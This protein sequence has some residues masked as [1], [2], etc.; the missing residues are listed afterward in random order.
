[1]AKTELGKAYVQIIPSAEGITGSISNVLDGEATSA[2]RSAGSRIS[3][4]IGTA[5]KAGGAVMAAGIAT[6]GAALV[7]LGSEAVNAYANFEQLSGGVET[8]FGESADLVMANADNAFKTAGLSANQYMETVTSFS[9]SLLQSTAGNTEE[10]A[11]IADMAL[12]DMADNANKMG[13][14]MQSIMNAYQGFAKGQYQLLDNL[15]LGYGGTQSEMER[16][17]ADATALSG[18]EYDIS[19][20]ADVYEAIHVIQSDIGITGTTALEASSTIQG[21]IG[22]MSAAWTN[23]IT[24]MADPS[25]DFDV[26]IGNL[27]DSVVGVADNIAPRI[28]AMVPRLVSGLVD[29]INALMPQIPP[30]VQ[31]LLPVFI[32]GIQGLLTS[33]IQMMP[34]LMNII[35]AAMPQIL[36]LISQILPMLVEVAAQIIITLANGLTAMMPDLIPV[37]IDMIVL[38]MN[39][40]IQNLPLIIEA[41]IQ[42][43]IALV[44]GILNNLPTVINGII[45]VIS[46]LISTIV[47]H[48][49]EIILMGVELLKSLLLGIANNLP[50]VVQSGIDLIVS[51][52]SGLIEAIPQIIAAMPEIIAAI[53]DTLTSVDWLGLGVNIVEGL[54]K[55]IASMASALI[56]VMVNLAKSA[57]QS[58]KEFFGIASPSKLM[59]WGGEMIGAGLAGG[60]TD[61][62][63]E[64]ENAVGG[65]NSS[66]ASGLLTDA[67]MS[68]SAS[69]AGAG[70]ITIPVYIGQERLD[71]IIL[72][73]QSRRNLVSGGR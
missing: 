15:K 38:I 2:G 34:E 63:T 27:V 67:S 1:M 55:G 10:A 73:A 54:I 25:Q 51:L 66:I 62:K 39:T 24:G 14:D 29:V 53:W 19:N 9:A 18:V 33:L 68:V 21:S 43:V 52:I 20:L 40:M 60:I 16:L 61:S 28:T 35:V 12:I 17:L 4:G 59:T 72:N 42:L 65:L 13:T 50:Q 6:T 47:E 70:N 8:L 71:T 31:T 41:G 56:D 11:N 36:A 30:L 46:T 23:F 69:V 58:V 57:W 49:P 3:S 22:Q 45:S 7:K 5:L 64:V 26:L 48:L 32:E 44:Q 37:I